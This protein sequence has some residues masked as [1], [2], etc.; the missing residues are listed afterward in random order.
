MR[1]IKHNRCI[2]L[3]SIM[4]LFG[5]HSPL[6][7]KPVKSIYNSKPED[8]DLE[9]PFP[10]GQ[11][12]VFRM[13]RVPGKGFW[14]DTDRTIQ[15]GDASGGI[16][17]GLQRLQVSGS[18]RDKATDHWVYYIGKYE[19]TKGQYIA[20]MGMDSFLAV[21]KDPEDKLLLSANE[22]SRNKAYA[23]PLSFVRY[24]DFQHFIER[25]NQWLFDPKHSERISQL[26]RN[27]NA[28][29]FI[30]LPTEVEW[31]FAARGGMI[32]MKNNYFDKPL[33][34]PRNKINRHV[35][36]VKNAKYK[37]RPIGLRK[38]NPLGIYDMFGNVQEVVD[39]RFLPEI[40]QG[41][42]G[43]IPVRGGS[44]S[45]PPNQLR[46]SLRT[47]LDAYAWDNDH[48]RVVERTSYNTGMRLAIGSNVVVS[49]KQKKRLE[50]EY[51]VYKTK[52]RQ[53][54]PVGQTLSNKV[55]QADKSLTNMS[56][57]MARLISEH[58]SLTSD[59]KSIQHYIDQAR[60]R[61]DSAQQ[62][63]TR[64][65]AQ[66]AVRNGVNLS[67]Y[68]SRTKSLKQALVKSKELLAISTRYQKNVDAVQ[69]KLNA[70]KES[71][72]EQFEAYK[73]KVVT[74]GEYDEK[75]VKQAYVILSAKKLSK[76]EAEVLHLLEQHVEDYHKYRRDDS[77]KWHSGFVDMFRVFND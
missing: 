23:K 12:M 11:V 42:P 32:A 76:R 61:L 47:E 50:N 69:E 24:T 45:T 1:I 13:V 58:P 53:N 20:L 59:L 63:N 3:L 44:V 16:F 67:V 70:I 75:Y 36:H 60:Q 37:I 62:E 56:P 18:F 27:A 65:L 46:A 64:S 35:W 8:G 39:G 49:P 38:P 33:P 7:A 5:L 25:Y 31:E 57:I 6:S 72:D 54:T 55:A 9:L 48:S 73:E 26:P 19:V 30:R 29:G 77:M 15:I 52:L 17:E 14:S 22:K 34:F 4:L 43:G 40:W 21:S 10:G 51:E 41:K 2:A 68:L 71:A 66:D 74:L 28:P